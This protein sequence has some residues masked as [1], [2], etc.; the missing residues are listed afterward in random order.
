MEKPRSTCW[1]S[2]VW[3]FDD[4]PTSCHQPFALR[5]HH[6]HSL[7]ILVS[8]I[9]ILSDASSAELNSETDILMRLQ[10][11]RTEQLEQAGFG[12]TNQLNR[13][14]GSWHCI[15]RYNKWNRILSP[16]GSEYP[17]RTSP[18]GGTKHYLQRPDDWRHSSRVVLGTA[19]RDTINETQ[20]WLLFILGESQVEW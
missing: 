14:N 13:Q 5:S 18:W 2:S 11:S 15:E 12:N 1:S 4:R 17:L 10:R 8:H 16:I 20:L 7:I 9:P 6:P 3:S 19:L